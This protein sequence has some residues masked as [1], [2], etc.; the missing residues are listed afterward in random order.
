MLKRVLTGRCAVVT[1]AVLLAAGAPLLVSCE[2]EEEPTGPSPPA[3]TYPHVNGAEWV[4][5][6]KGEKAAKY[7]ISGN[8][9]HPAAGPTQKLYEYV[10]GESGWEENFVYYLQ[11]ISSSGEVRQERVRLYVDAEES[12]FIFL[13]Q[14]PLKVGDSWDAGLGLNANVSAKEDVSVPAG[15]FECYKIDY[16]SSTA[17]FTIWW[18]SKVGGI[19]AKDRGWWSV[20]GKPITMELAS[21]KLPT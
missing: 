17:S 8:F 13:L 12:K 6:Y 5:N 18:P 20:G 4:Y 19:G 15:S 16:A 3:F 21:Y 10:M 2:D 14:T 7:T 1:A 11:V 9:E